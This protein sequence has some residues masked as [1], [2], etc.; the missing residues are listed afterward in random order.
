MKRWY[1]IMAD[2]PNI[3]DTKGLL[4]LK[5]Q[6][7]LSEVVLQTKYFKRRGLIRHAVKYGFW[8][9]K[10]GGRLRICDDGPS[11]FDVRPGS[12]P[13]SIVRQQVFKILGTDAELEE[14][15]DESWR[16]VVRRTTAPLSQGF[17]AGV[18]FSGNSSELPALAKTLDGLRAQPELAAANGGSIVV[19]GP[20]SARAD[21]AGQKG[22]DYLSFENEPGHRAFTTRKKNALIAALPQPRVAIMH[23]RMVLTPGCLSSLPIEFDAITPRVEYREQDKVV[24]YLDWTMAPVLD[25]ETV[26]RGLPLPYNYNRARYLD[27]LSGPGRPMIDGGLF[28]VRRSLAIKVPLNN[29]LAWGE[30]EDTEWCAR[31]H[32]GGALVDLAPEALALSQSMKFPRRYIENPMLVKVMQPVSRVLKRF[33]I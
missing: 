29:D 23:A 11:S 16:I 6:Q 5:K 15:D 26:P 31:L 30:A 22:V 33:C 18:I 4:W 2:I 7:N 3:L 24:P 12:L 32:A 21:I 13:F 8:S 25:A 14:L 9:L 27:Y 17:G 10:K 20:E 28:I 1:L 19:C